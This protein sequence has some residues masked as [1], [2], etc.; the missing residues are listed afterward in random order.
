MF[1]F[2]RVFLSDGMVLVEVGFRAD[3]LTAPTGFEGHA[4]PYKQN[5]LRLRNDASIGRLSEVQ[6]TFQHVSLP[7]ETPNAPSQ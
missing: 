5:L 6:A 3:W 7:P 2:S 1:V 4:H